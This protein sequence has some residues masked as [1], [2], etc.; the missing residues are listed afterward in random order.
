MRRQFIILLLFSFHTKLLL[1]GPN[2]W[3]SNN[4][5]VA[6]GIASGS[7]EQAKSESCA[8]ARRSLIEYVFG[9]NVKV[10][11]KS[12][13]TLDQAQLSNQI[14]TSSDRVKLIGIA[15]SNALNNT[16]TTCLLKYP[17]REA[18]I[19]RKRLL[20]E[21]ADIYVEKN[22]VE[23]TS[24][25]EA[26]L[27]QRGVVKFE[28]DP[29]ESTVEID[30][31]IL[32]E[33]PCSREVKFGSHKIRF[34]KVNFDTVEK[35]ILHNKKELSV[36]VKLMENVGTLHITDLPSGSRVYIDSTEFISNSS[37]DETIKV[38]PSD[39]VVSVKNDEYGPFNR[40]VSLH[41]GL[42]TS[43]NFQGI[44]KTGHL[45]L[46]AVDSKGNALAADIIIDGN[47]ITEKTPAQIIVP[48]G[49]REVILKYQSL[50]FRSSH[51]INYKETTTLVGTLVEKEEQKEKPYA[52]HL[53]ISPWVIGMGFG[54]Y[55]GTYSGNSKGSKRISAILGRRFL[56]FMG[57][58]GQIST[59]SSGTED[60]TLSGNSFQLALPIFI[61]QWYIKPAVG[62]IDH[63]I[64]PNSVTVKQSYNAFSCGYEFRSGIIF[65]TLEFGISKY[66]D[67]GNF[68]GTNSG[69]GSYSFLI[70][71]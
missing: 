56:G 15:T 23:V 31:A 5:Y 53:A 25:Q 65:I 26:K 27:N 10:E 64:Q 69:F 44:R 36:S 33:T 28:S 68:S 59:D 41:K 24:N 2:V 32:C 63:S 43:I 30:G 67:F 45:N 51:R 40:K 55:D 22:L 12:F 11:E 8:L 49:A 9:V 70:A 47:A 54:G 7:N 3:T 34:S 42:T 20:S 16:N 37:T 38:K 61:S 71:F 35:D 52:E 58:E 19:E 46:S 18:D 48:T 1:A 21:K 4:Y 50:E 66:S 60:G 57:L 29:L 39:Y 17:I 6:T 13:T 62:Q 14:S